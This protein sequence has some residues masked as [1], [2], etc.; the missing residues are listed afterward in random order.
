MHEVGI[1]QNVLD[2]AVEKA[3]REGATHIQLVQLRVGHAT[4]IMPESLQL[5]FDVVRKGTIAEDAYL[6][7]DRVPTICYCWHCGADFEPMDELYE[8][9][10]CQQIST[11]IRQG[12]EFELKSLVVS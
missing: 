5:A 9:P 8:C 11:E 12:K 3:K 10:Q 2:T 6:Y 7:I 4:G 1:M